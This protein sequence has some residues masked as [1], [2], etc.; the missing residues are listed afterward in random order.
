ME[1]RQVIRS[2]LNELG[3][4]AQR[5]NYNAVGR[6]LIKCLL[7]VDPQ[8]NPGSLQYAIKPARYYHHNVQET[9]SRTRTHARAKLLISSLLQFPFMFTLLSIKIDVCDVIYVRFGPYLYK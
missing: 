9:Q 7:Y 3:N 4:G 8:S 2:Q 6:Y 1:A 5:N